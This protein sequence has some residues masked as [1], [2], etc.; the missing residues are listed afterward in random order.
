MRLGVRILDASGSTNY[1]IA[2]TPQMASTY[3]WYQFWYR[4]P[5]HTDGTGV[6]L[7]SALR[8]VFCP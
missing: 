1:P 3:R 8:V 4:D 6:G 5:F 7:S 2:V